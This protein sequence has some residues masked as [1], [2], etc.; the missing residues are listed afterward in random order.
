MIFTNGWFSPG[1]CYSSIIIII[2]A[3]K[4]KTEQV[5]YRLGLSWHKFIIRVFKAQFTQRVKHLWSSESH[6]AIIFL[7]HVI[8]IATMICKLCRA[9]HRE[10]PGL[11]TK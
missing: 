5:Q 6:C 11:R 3:Y 2:A 7:K 4:L 1:F 9:F 8:V 10:L